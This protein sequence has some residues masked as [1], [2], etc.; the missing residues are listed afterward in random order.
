MDYEAPSTVLMFTAC[1][2]RSC[3]NVTIVDD[4]VDELEE[5]FDVTLERTPG[6]DSRIRINPADGQILIIDNDGKPWPRGVCIS[7]CVG[8]SATLA[9]LHEASICHTHTNQRFLHGSVNGIIV[10]VQA[11][12][13]TGSIEF[14]F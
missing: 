2:I 11:M 7:C 8:V 6:L 13:H 12:A 5:I 1:E 10:F 14:Y 4:V 3:V 9:H